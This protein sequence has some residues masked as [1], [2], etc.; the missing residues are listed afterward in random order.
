MSRTATL[1]G[2]LLCFL[3]G[4]T[5]IA[6]AGKT[7]KTD[8]TLVIHSTGVSG[9]VTSPNPKCI[10]GRRVTMEMDSAHGHQH[11]PAT[12]TGASGR[13]HFTISVPDSY[14]IQVGVGARQLSHNGPYANSCGPASKYRSK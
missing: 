11:P 4:I 3:L 10:E 6:V 14:L 13:W 9:Q 1:T 5:A 8:T 7:F 2:L 12:H